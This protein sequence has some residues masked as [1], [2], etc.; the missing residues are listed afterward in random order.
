MFR[1][2]ENRAWTPPNMAYL[3]QLPASMHSGHGHWSTWHISAL[4]QCIP[5]PPSDREANDPVTIMSGPDCGRNSDR[6]LQTA[7]RD[8]GDVSTTET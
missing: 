4:T 1:Q 6:Y 2:R 8:C 3:E 7:E 5:A